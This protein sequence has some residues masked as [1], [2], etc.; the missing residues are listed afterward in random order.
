MAGY[1]RWVRFYV[2][3]FAVVVAGCGF[4]GP[5]AKGDATGID[6]A[7][8]I[9]DV[10]SPPS[11]SDTIS[12]AKPPPPDAAMIDAA[13]IDAVMID[14]VAP[15]IQL[16][17][18]NDAN[19]G[20]NI[21]AISVKFVQAQLAGDLNVVVVGWFMAGTVTS[22][23]DTSGNLY[24]IATGPASSGPE[25]QTIYYKCGIA[26]AAANANTVVV[27]FA[28]ATQQPDVH[29]IEYSGTRAGACLDRAVSATGSGT[30]MSVGSLATTHAHDLLV[31]A[32]FQVNQATTGDPSYTSRGID[33]F[34]D[35]VEDREVGATGT[36]QALAT[37]NTSGAWVMQLAAFEGL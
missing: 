1:T 20:T 13:M 17:Q 25:S 33:N 32:T 14:A 16:R 10:P 34:G 27:T 5:G 15:P 8:E 30:A 23:V 21:G 31:A 3:V 4:R 26:G 36:Y 12:D 18:I 19:S 28:G 24:A 6:D 9:H 22:V 11:D 37:Q 29:V 35:L 2:F 7:T